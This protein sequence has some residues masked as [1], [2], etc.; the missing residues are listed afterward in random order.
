MV[1]VWQ[2]FQSVGHGTFF[3][4]SVSDSD[5]ASFS[6]AYD[7]GSKRP[8]RVVEAV[9]SLEDTQGWSPDHELDMVVVSHFDADHINGL[10]ALLAQHRVKCLVLPFLGVQA[11]LAQIFT[12]TDGETISAPMAAFA[13]DPVR[14]LRDRGLSNRV[15]SILLIR[16]GPSDGAAD[17]GIGLPLHPQGEERGGDPRLDALS[18]EVQAY[19]RG[20]FDEPAE[21][22]PAVTVQSHEIPVRARNGLPFEFVFY[23]TAL[24]GGVAKRSGL[25]IS[26]VQNEVDFI[27]RTYRLQQPQRK[28]RSGW[29]DSL[30]RCYDKH[31]GKLG[32]ER[33]NISLCVF[34][35]PLV[36]AR[37]YPHRES[38]VYS[39]PYP[40]LERFDFHWPHTPY[41]GYCLEF[42]EGAD[43]LKRS[44]RQAL[45]L[46]GDLALNE[47]EIRSMQAHFGTPRWKEIGLTQ[48][49]HHGS[50]HSWKIGNAK[51]F[52]ASQFVL[53]VPTISRHH[54]HPHPSVITDLA[55]ARSHVADYES[56]V[57]HHFCFPV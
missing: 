8:T 24:P 23:N 1:H 28:P 12:S 46:T 27:F 44:D 47:D 35:R 54:H 4:G 37:A 2:Q 33:N 19:P 41:R 10:E 49:P 5:G 14:Y 26:A 16:G 11:R 22:N 39:A 3:T 45:L 20:Y 38:M 29:R 17:D 43:M 6:W 57:I 9:A 30:K 25:P 51:H 13:M 50:R 42:F 53:C 56:S 15:D 31:F 52:A 48:V 21:G 32:N 34:A 18:P 36:D 55:R 40:D 7:C